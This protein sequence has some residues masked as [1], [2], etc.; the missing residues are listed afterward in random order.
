MGTAFEELQ[1]LKALVLA[2][3]GNEMVH[4]VRVDQDRQRKRTNTGPKQQKRFSVDCGSPEAFRELY[5]Q[6]DRILAE[7]VNKTIALDLI[8]WWLTLLTPERIKKK[9]EA[10]ERLAPPK[11]SLPPESFIKP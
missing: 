3:K 4:I 10:G 2:G 8:T 11:A 7:V 6:Y 5:T 1:T 9:M